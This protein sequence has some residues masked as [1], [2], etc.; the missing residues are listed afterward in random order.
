MRQMQEQLGKMLQEMRDKA[1]K[2]Q[3]KGKPGT[4]EQLARMAAEQEAIREKMQQ[5]LNSLQA[6]GK[7]GES[8]LK[9]IIEEMEQLEEDLVNKRVNQRL[10]ERQKEIVSRLLESE[11]KVSKGARRRKSVNLMNL[12]VIISVTL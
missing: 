3:G 10:F 6:E 9:K 2:E 11:K 7:L 12:K 1:G 4:S 8:E 5:Y